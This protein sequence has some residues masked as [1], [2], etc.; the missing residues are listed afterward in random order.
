MLQQVSGAIRYCHGLGKEKQLCL[1][2]PPCILWARSSALSRV[3][4]ARGRRCG[5]S[6]APGSQAGMRSLDQRQREIIWVWGLNIPE[7]GCHQ[8]GHMAADVILPWARGHRMVRS[9]SCSSTFWAHAQFQRTEK[10]LH[11]LGHHLDFKR[12]FFPS[13]CKMIKRT[14]ERISLR[15]CRARDFLNQAWKA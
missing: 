1:P 15:S 4:G 8:S 6:F 13:N 7:P 5:C 2:L 14:Y 9:Q 10:H 12:I 3:M 11:F